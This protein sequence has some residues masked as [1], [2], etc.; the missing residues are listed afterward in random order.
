MNAICRRFGLAILSALAVTAM[1]ATPALTA[2]G[3]LDST[4][5]GDG[6]V[7]TN[8]TLGFDSANGVAIQEDGNMRDVSQE[9]IASAAAAAFGG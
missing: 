7:T 5:G 3:N 8:F 1:S 9:E 6:K 4:F 2:P